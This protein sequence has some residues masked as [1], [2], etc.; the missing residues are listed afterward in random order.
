MDTNGDGDISHSPFIR[1]NI[2]SGLHANAN[3]AQ[4]GVIDRSE[5]DQAAT[6][7]QFLKEHPQPHPLRHHHT[8]DDILRSNPEISRLN[9]AMDL[10]QRAADQAAWMESEVRGLNVM[11]FLNA[12]IY[13]KGI[14]IKGVAEMSVPKNIQFWKIWVLTANSKCISN[15]IV[16]YC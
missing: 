9:Q 2:T 11:C 13:N 3:T 15:V 12:A 6:V 16:N 8:D 14:I 10:R 4:T 7:A 1:A 5:W